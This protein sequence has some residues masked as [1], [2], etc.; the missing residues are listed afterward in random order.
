MKEKKKKPCIW[1]VS[2][3]RIKG[4]IDILIELE[5]NNPRIGIIYLG[6]KK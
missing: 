4:D 2:E 1:L 6:E 3:K 5:R